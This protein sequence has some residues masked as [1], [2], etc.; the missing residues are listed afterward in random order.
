MKESGKKTV[1][2]ITVWSANVIQKILMNKKY[3]GDMIL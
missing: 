2:G 1:T 3:M